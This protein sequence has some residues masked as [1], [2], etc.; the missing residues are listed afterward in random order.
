[1]KNKNKPQKGQPCIVIER[2]YNGQ[3]PKLTETKI[4]SAG[5]KWIFVDYFYKTNKFDSETLTSDWGGY[6]L[7][8]GTMEEFNEYCKRSAEEKKIRNEIAHFIENAELEQLISIKEVIDK[9]QENG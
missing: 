4:I 7:F 9:I 5:S 2:K 6:D 8:I 1:M 3:P